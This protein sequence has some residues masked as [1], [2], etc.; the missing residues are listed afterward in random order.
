LFI[1]VCLFSC[2]AAVKPSN[3][4]AIQRLHHVVPRS[5]S[6]NCALLD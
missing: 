5:E 6:H 4:A 2:C 3:E 1:P